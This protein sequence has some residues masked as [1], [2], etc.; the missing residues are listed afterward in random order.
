[1]T[2]TGTNSTF[3]SI[4]NG[5]DALCVPINFLTGNEFICTCKSLWRT[6]IGRDTQ[7]QIHIWL[8]QAKSC[9]WW[10]IQ[11][12]RGTW[13]TQYNLNQG[14]GVIIKHFLFRDLKILWNNC[15]L[16]NKS[17]IL[18]WPTTHLAQINPGNVNTKYMR[19]EY[20]QCIPIRIF[21]RL[22]AWHSEVYM[23]VFTW[24]HTAKISKLLSLMQHGCIDQQQGQT[25]S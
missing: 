22:S 15:M 17:H 8:L 21:S 14:Q 12:H 5:C 9:S 11:S 1:M 16:E 6:L 3:T 18:L 19:S 25:F 13:N 10:A 7:L 4:G 2:W 24:E 20:L 23:H